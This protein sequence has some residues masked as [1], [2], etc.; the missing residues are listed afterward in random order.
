VPVPDCV[1]PFKPHISK[2]SSDELQ[3][4]NEPID[5]CTDGFVFK[6]AVALENSANHNVFSA[7]VVVL[8]VIER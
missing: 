2:P 8:T 1:A 5:N 7:V 4:F 6:S 3:F